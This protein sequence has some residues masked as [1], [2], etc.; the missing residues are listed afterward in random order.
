MK[1]LP[2][3]RSERIRFRFVVVETFAI[4]MFLSSILVNLVTRS[5][6]RIVVRSPWNV[7]FDV[8]LPPEYGKPLAD[9]FILS[10]LFP[11]ISAPI[12]FKNNRQMGTAAGI[13]AV[14]IFILGCI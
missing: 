5:I 14:L 6:G 4:A 10:L 12:L 7:Q 2:S 1:V 8:L 11:G 13:T 3:K 9:L